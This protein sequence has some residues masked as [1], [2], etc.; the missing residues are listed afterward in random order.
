MTRKYQMTRV[1]RGDYL[2]PSNDLTTLWRIYSYEEDGSATDGAGRQ[3]TGT[4][5]GAAK[6]HRGM[7]TEHDIYSE[8]FLEYWGDDWI[9]WAH[10]L[11]TRGEAIEAALTGS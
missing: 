5:W 1:R 2:L 11:R 4:F 3:I 7:P 6:W 10:G 9:H 8:D